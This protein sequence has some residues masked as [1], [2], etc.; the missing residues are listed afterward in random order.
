M[1]F[2]MIK[3]FRRFAMKYRIKLEESQKFS[4]LTIFLG[5]LTFCF[6]A[7]KVPALITWTSLFGTL[8]SAVFMVYSATE[9]TRRRDYSEKLEAEKK[10]RAKSLREA[11]ALNALPLVLT[12]NEKYTSG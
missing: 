8:A 4:I 2:L 1:V 5:L 9:E 7:L 12:R 6:L 11:A 3:T 10:W